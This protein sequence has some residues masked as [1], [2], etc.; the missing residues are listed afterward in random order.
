MLSLLTGR[1]GDDFLHEIGEECHIDGFENGNF[2]NA[3]PFFVLIPHPVVFDE[4][5]VVD[6]PTTPNLVDVLTSASVLLGEVNADEV[7]D[8]VIAAKGSGLETRHSNP[9][10][11][12]V[13]GSHH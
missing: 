7:S 4:I 2:F 6:A 11:G 8:D 10:L 1:I 13:V 9:A 5:E 3:F 12:P